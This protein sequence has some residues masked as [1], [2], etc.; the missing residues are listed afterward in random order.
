MGNKTSQN[1]IF[2]IPG[3][4]QKPTDKCFTWLINLLQKKGF[5][6]IK[7]SID[8]DYR[9]MTD[10]V[11]DFKQQYEKYSGKNNYILGF[12]Y[13][14][15]IAFMSATELKPKK[16]YLC[17]LSPHFKEDIKAMKPWIKKLVGKRRIADAKK[18]SAL[19]IA[20]KLNIPSTIFYGEIEAE[21]FPQLVVRAKETLKYAKNVK[22]IIVKE[23]RIKLTIQSI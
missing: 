21:K 11:A 23:A 12:S 18:Q 1:R 14:A 2:L 16:I 7:I 19:T 17:S 10:Y 4:G 13:G 9:V 5:E 20:R 6:V 22:I 8:W 15:V 3:W